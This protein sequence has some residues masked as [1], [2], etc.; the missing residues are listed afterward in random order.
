MRI[1]RLNMDNTWLLEMEGLRL[2]IDP[3]LEGEEVDYFS[4]FNTQ[5]HRTKPLSYD[6]LPV[7]DVV[8]IT[9]KYPDHFHPQTLLRLQPKKIIAPISI[10]KKLMALLPNATVIGMNKELSSITLN[11]VE[12]TWYPTSRKID[13]IYDAFL[14]QDKKEAVF[15]A[16]HG[17][18]I[19]KQTIQITKPLKLL[20]SPF[21]HF[22]LPIYL[23]GVVSPGIEGLKHLTENLKPAHIIATHDEDKHAKGLV[24]KMAK[25]ERALTQD[26]AEFPLFKN[27]ILE[28]N[29]YTSVEL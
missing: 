24:I 2:L 19:G 22:K 1:Q 15:L 28:L 3:W 4:W 14:I 8:L 9:Q 7:Y 23:G 13:P 11:A 6:K 29:H 25:I 20:I 21:N 26:L 16:T 18:Y 10:K 17:Y 12:I 5:W 27:K